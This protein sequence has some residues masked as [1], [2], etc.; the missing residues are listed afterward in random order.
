MS[1]ELSAMYTEAQARIKILNC[2]VQQTAGAWVFAPIFG[3]ILLFMLQSSSVVQ[4][5]PSPQ[6][7]PRLKN[8]KDSDR[9]TS[10]AILTH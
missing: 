8:P 4:H 5:G 2:L 1:F 6:G 10:L 3:P 9:M 7:T